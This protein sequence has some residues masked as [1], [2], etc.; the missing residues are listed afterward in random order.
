MNRSDPTESSLWVAEV[1]THHATHFIFFLQFADKTIGEIL[2]K[3]EK[4]NRFLSLV[5]V[6]ISSWCGKEQKAFAK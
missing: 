1:N 4:F 6:S 5:D 3:D 2:T